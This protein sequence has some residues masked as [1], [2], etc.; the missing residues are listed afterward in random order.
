M[1]VL[2]NTYS[3]ISQS[4]SSKFTNNVDKT[5]FTLFKTS[6]VELKIENN[7]KI[8][9]VALN[10]VDYVAYLGVHLDSTLSWKVQIS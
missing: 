4:K 2:K 10:K 8:G 3:R 1:T 9:D 5:K 6:R 7:L